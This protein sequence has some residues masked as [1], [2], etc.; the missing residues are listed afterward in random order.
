MRKILIFSVIFYSSL[1]LS[2][3]STELESLIGSWRNQAC[4]PAADDQ[5]FTAYHIQFAANGQL[6]TYLQSYETATCDGS[7]GAVSQRL[8]G[9][10]EVMHKS[11]TN[12][13]IYYDLSF[14]HPRLNYLRAQ[15]VIIQ[16]DVLQL[17]PSTVS[18]R[19]A[20]FNK[21]V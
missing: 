17:C 12:S 9:I 20:Y 19:C 2:S 3:G 21:V 4:Q 6:I 14:H 16:G 13:Q 5:N 7:G 15:R 18:G 8:F 1:S 10:Y 11:E